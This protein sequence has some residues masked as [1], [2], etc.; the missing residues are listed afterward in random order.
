MVTTIVP[1]VTQE[2]WN[3]FPYPLC[4]SSS[5]DSPRDI[6][7]LLSGEGLDEVEQG[8]LLLLLWY[9]FLLARLHEIALSVH[10]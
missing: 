5:G 9:S 8:E 7:S 10:E 3:F 2:Q 1:S 4:S 6:S